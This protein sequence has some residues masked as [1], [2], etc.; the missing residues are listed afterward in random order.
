MKVIERW[1]EFYFH[2]SHLISSAFGWNGNCFSVRSY[3]SEHNHGIA[4][5]I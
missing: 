1:P 5:V 3:A 4:N 2:A